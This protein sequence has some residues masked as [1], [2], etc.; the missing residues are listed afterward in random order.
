MKAEVGISL[1]NLCVFATKQQKLNLLN[2]G[3]LEIFSDLLQQYPFHEEKFLIRILEGLA[4]L[5]Q[6]GKALK[7]IV[8]RDL[9]R[10]NVEKTRIPKVLEELQEHAN[11]KIYTLC[12][13]LLDVFF[14]EEQDV[15]E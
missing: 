11:E 3:L 9:I 1:S 6:L 5:L 2:R 10:E 7:T 15:C 4:A 14:A 13:K 12:Y 8:G